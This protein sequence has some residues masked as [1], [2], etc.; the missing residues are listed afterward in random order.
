M[1]GVG[2]ISC[3]VDFFLRTDYSR[4]SNLVHFGIIVDRHV[5][6]FS[7]VLIDWFCARGAHVSA[8]ARDDRDA[9]ESLMH[10]NSSLHS[11]Q[12]SA[13]SLNELCE[14]SRRRFFSGRPPGGDRRVN[15]PVVIT[16]STSAL[17]AEGRGSTPRRSTTFGPQAFAFGP[18][19]LRSGGTEYH[20][21]LVTRLR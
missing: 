16:A 11:F 19:S 8:L 10:R 4:A 13:E 12:V 7:V 2:A 20:R 15:G 1:A 9:A 3:W 14:S 5:L 21:R 17:Q 6:W 18:V